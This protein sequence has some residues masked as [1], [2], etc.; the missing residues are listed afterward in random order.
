MNIVNLSS[1]QEL[2]MDPQEK[3]DSNAYQELFSPC[4]KK[5]TTLFAK[6]GQGSYLITT[7]DEKYLDLVQGIAVNQLG[8]CHPE[9]VRAATEQIS[10][11]SHASF[12]LLHYPNVLELAA[13]LKKLTPGNLNKFFFTNSGAEAVEGALKLA[14]YVSGKTSFIAF[15]GAFHGRT[16]GAASVTA[17]NAGARSHYAPFMPQVYFAPYP[18]CFRCPFH[19]HADT[20]DLNCLQYLKK[21]LET[22]IPADDVAGVIIEPVQGEGGYI[23]PPVRYVQALS[24]LC[25]E[26]DFYLIF[27]EIQSGIG[28]TGKMFAAEHYGVIPDIM[29]LGKAVGGGLPMSVVVSTS[30][31][32]DQW[33]AGTHG[34]TFGGHPVAAA[35]GLAQLKIVS[36]KSFLNEVMIKG[37]NFR[38]KLQELQ[39]QFEVIG[40][41]R[42]LGLM[43]AIEIVKAD[44][45][46]DPDLTKKITEFFFKENILL[47]T[48]GTKGN[49]I[50]FMPALNIEEK[51][52]DQTVSVLK[53]ALSQG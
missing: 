34:T 15:R 50:R 47:F 41:V 1:L 6:S 25:K 2:I 4:L 5:A 22:V 39:K 16:M 12:N 27:D 19:A 52:L 20:C 13:E 42:G 8:H 30:D 29:T 45:V 3:L 33:A 46:P 9:L 44:K 11:L 18:Y 21:D 49:M 36:K 40:D 48:C 23:V 37:E 35:T 38:N 32:M 43:N 53:R 31:I 7:E 28:R 26:H 24:Q 14:R 17:S 51:L 10:R